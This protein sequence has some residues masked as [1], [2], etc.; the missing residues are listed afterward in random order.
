MCSYHM[1]M[2]FSKVITKDKDAGYVSL[3][4]VSRSNLIACSVKPE[5]DIYVSGKTF[6]NFLNQAIVKW[7]NELE[8]LLLSKVILKVKVTRKIVSLPLTFTY[9]FQ[10]SAGISSDLRRMINNI[11]PCFVL[12]SH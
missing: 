9:M 10:Y 4:N 5:T 1:R 12:E 6:A 7:C 11:Y 3:K 2:I 8:Q